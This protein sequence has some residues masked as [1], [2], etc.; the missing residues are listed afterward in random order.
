MTRT[1][2]KAVK[3]ALPTIT[4]G[5][6]ARLEGRL[7]AGT[8]SGSKAAR[9]LRGVLRLGSMS[10]PASPSGRPDIGGSGSPAP[11]TTRPG[12]AGWDIPGDPSAPGGALCD[13]TAYLH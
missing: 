2:T 4:R 9:G 11:S 1:S 7:G 8:W 10:D 6:R 13:F 12:E 5:L 3:T